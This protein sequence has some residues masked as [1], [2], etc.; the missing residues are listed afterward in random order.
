M[1][2]PPQPLTRPASGYADPIGARSWPELISGRLTDIAS[3]GRWRAP[4]QLAT[5]TTQT[6]TADGRDVINFASNDYL[7]FA[8]HPAVVEAARRA[9]AAFGAGAGSARLITGDR[10]I[11]HELEDALAEAKG[12]EAAVLFSTGY[13]A[14]LGALTALATVGGPTTRIY[15]DELNHA[16]IIDASRL[17]RAPVTVYP[18]CEPPDRP[19]AT[20]GGPALVVSDSVFSMDGDV[21]P[22]ADMAA[23]ATA[24]Q[25]MLVL[26]EAHCVFD[27]FAA[28]LGDALASGHVLRVGT[29]SKALGSMGGFVAGRRDVIDLLINTAR[30]YIFTTAMPPG[31][32]AAALAAL[33]ISRSAEGADRRAQLR[34][35]IDMIVPGHPSPI[36]P[37]VIGGEQ[38]AL[39]IAAELFRL[40]FVVPAIRPPTVA[41]GTCRLRVTLS[42]DHTAADV[43]R[44]T[45]S[46]DTLGVAW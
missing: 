11:H 4:R 18:H 42:A 9:T 44:L 30:P 37:I 25:H 43:D 27:P 24:D 21:A 38:Q 41:P 14:N 10:S 13:M 15:S 20:T 22:V 23:A 7:G 16:S 12:A 35:L 31:V 6:T 36:V 3:A 32:A 46:L 39:D 45:D 19:T 26:D 17:S 28:A 8:A 29:L 1:S 34:S 2:T 33:Q 5:T 40:G